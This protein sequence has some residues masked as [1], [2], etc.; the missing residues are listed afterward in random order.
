MA[1]FQ[2]YQSG[3][4]PVTGMAEAG[5]NIGNM[6]AQGLS[7]LGKG[8]AEGIKAFNDN[9]AKNELANAKIQSLSQDVANKIAMYSQDPEIAQSGVLDGLMQTAATLQDAPT[10]GLNQRLGLVHEAETR[11][12]GF[13]QQL[14]EW[15]F[16]RGRQIERGISDAL[17]KFAGTVTTTDS[18]DVND[19]MFNVN[20]NETI[21]QTKDRLFKILGEVKK[22]NPKAQI[23]NDEFYA[24]WLSKAEQEVAKA[25][26]IDPRI[27]SAQLEAIQ[28]EKSIQ[29]QN[30]LAQGM[31]ATDIPS[32]DALDQYAALAEP[33]MN[34]VKDYEAMMA[35]PA[36]APA[37]AQKQLEQDTADALAFFN[38]TGAMLPKSGEVLTGD[39]KY[40]K[41]VKELR[42][43]KEELEAR[44][45]EVEKGLEWSAIFGRWQAP[46]AS[47]HKRRYYDETGKEMF[48]PE[49]FAK[50]YT[51]YQ[52]DVDRFDA[53]MAYVMPRRKKQKAE[54]EE[55][56]AKIEKTN[57]ELETV[58][59]SQ[60]T[61]DKDE[62]PIEQILAERKV[63]E[64]APKASEQAV[65]S[66]FGK[67]AIA[68]TISELENTIRTDGNIS[69]FDLIKK[70]N[71]FEIQNNPTSRAV[72]MPAGGY[73]VNP[74]LRLPS[75]YSDASERIAKEAKRL[76]ISPNQPMTADQMSSLMGALK[77]QATEIAKSAKQSAE[78][79]AQIK[80]ENMKLG[81][82]SAQ[83]ART[84]VPT[85]GVGDV[86]VGTQENT[87]P[88]TVSEKKSQVQDFLT[89]RFGAVDPTDPTGKRRIPV[90]GFDQFFAKAVPESEIREFTTEGGTRLLQINGKWEQVKGA[91]RQS[92]QDIR[93][94]RIGVFGQQTADG[95]LVPT[96]FVEGSGIYLGGLYRG[97]DAG[98]DKFT[99]E[100]TQLVDARRGVKRLQEINDKFGEAFSLKDSGEAAVEVMNLKAALRTDIIGVGTVSNFEQA[101]IDKVIKD[102]TEF[103]SMEPRDRAILL[104]LANRI[105]RRIKNIS[106]SRGLTVQIR[107]TGSKESR[108]NDLRQRYLREK[109]L[110]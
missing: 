101:L 59:R 48:P 38:G 73:G 87:R 83:Q 11:L 93:K 98:A 40:D 45:K 51:G 6:Y 53:A 97:T 24:R 41:R 56:E 7:N 22:L 3:I 75:K 30:R 19:P 2:Q 16:L 80:P 69:V 8:L 13:G 44:K 67:K 36:D 31:T 107:D 46:M 34:T 109:G 94:E 49:D 55:I 62:R 76:G 35:T 77:G 64:L 60:F 5:A 88:L 63:K 84:P 103:L 57:S 100:I 89:Q 58:D 25:Q 20:P 91:E 82:Q 21:T 72:T 42:K 14:Q 26:D 85:I 105:D 28:A 47:G 37:K 54:L 15:S 1:M 66:E 104:A 108:Y 39:Q 4:Q 99:D 81:V 61:N 12:A 18:I 9:S 27:I 52:E 68:T 32:S 70:T 71:E 86:V 65:V 50:T 90:Q 23:N 43:T 95:R 110:L 106:S 29:R 74:N 17:Q 79:L 78:N 102:P 96:E 92:I 33:Q 10:K